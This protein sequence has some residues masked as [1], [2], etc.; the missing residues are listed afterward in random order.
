V[1]ERL[2]PQK[3]RHV[4]GYVVQ[5]GGRDHIEYLE[6]DVRARIDADL[7]CQVVPL[8]VS[9]LAIVGARQQGSITNETRTT[10]LQRIEAGLQFLGIRYELVLPEP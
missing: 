1:F 5:V 6:G 7:L 2:A 4:S 3:A 10:I 9:T 8:Y